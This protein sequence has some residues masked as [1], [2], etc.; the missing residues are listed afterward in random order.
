[1]GSPAAFSS[2]A[3]ASDL[4]LYR[5]PAT[6][7]DVSG[8]P[9]LQFVAIQEGESGGPLRRGTIAEGDYILL[10]GE[11]EAAANLLV[12]MHLAFRDEAPRPARARRRCSTAAPVSPR[13]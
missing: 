10:R 13:W 7:V 8:F 4:S 12:K 2:A 9:G 11:A 1:M 5:Q 6:A 3:R